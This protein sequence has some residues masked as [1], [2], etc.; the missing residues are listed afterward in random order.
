MKRCDDCIGGYTCEALN[1]ACLHTAIRPAPK[2]KRAP[3][4]PLRQLA[5][6]PIK[7]QNAKRRQAEFARC[8][9]SRGRVAFVKSLPCPVCEAVGMSGR[10]TVQRE[11]AHVVGGGAGRKAD[12]TAIVPLCSHH[13][14][15]LH[16]AGSL[17]AFYVT[18]G[19]RV[20]LAREAARVE[21]LWQSHVATTETE[22][23]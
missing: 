18:F 5:R 4:K 13:H 2:P 10:W 14:R 12:F 22:K 9:H 11:N 6:T 20:D 16:A 17:S 1:G 3:K 19:G 21:A 23:T 7:K 15:A 8:Y